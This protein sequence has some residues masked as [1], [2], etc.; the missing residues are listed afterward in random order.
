MN[1]KVR[2][3]FAIF[4]LVLLLI[5]ESSSY[6]GIKGIDNL[7]YV[8]AIGLDIGDKENLNLSLQISVPNNSGSSSDSSQSSSV[9]VNSIECPSISTGI[10]L[11]NSYL[12][13][14]VN[15]SHCKVLV[16]S[17][18]L[19][20]QGIEEYLYTLINDVQFRSDSNLIISK[21]DAKTYLEYS[22][23]VLDKVSARY[24]E[25]APT[26]SEY[27][28]YTES[29]S[30]NEFLSAMTY[31]SAEPVAI[32]GSI[33]TEQ[34]QKVSSESSNNSSYY[35]A[36]QTPI[37]GES[38]VENMGLAVFNNDKLV[39][40]LNGLESICHLIISN[41]LKNAQI[42]IP[43]PIENLDYIDLY[44][45][46]EKQTKSSVYLT[47]STPYIKSKIKV[48][49]KMQSMN[50]NIDLTDDTLTSKIEKSA[51]AFLKE[52]ISNYLYKTSKELHS[53]IDQFGLYAL[54]YFN[55]QEEWNSYNWLHH[56][57]DAF[58]DVNVDVNLRSSYLLV[59][60]SEGT[61]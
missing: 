60:T 45:E 54:K 26:S 10:T 58:F 31:N 8:V 12:G 7:A 5:I 27:T 44:I 13:K 48:N 22:A 24:Y 6:Y 15:L 56:Y 19:A 61:K 38:G 57:K 55:T 4:I 2:K 47:N 25:I 18:E 52:K 9:V 53:D 46:L 43:S 32:L 21:C 23:P 49:A 1:F 29:I 20:S 14:E 33:N 50:R 35:T 59:D 3:I 28:G 42:R 37:S 51:E 30:C 39:G 36:G 41:K 11:F 34:T 40:E 17:E 16:I